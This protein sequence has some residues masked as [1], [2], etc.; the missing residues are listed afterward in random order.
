MKP[1]RIAVK[2]D[3]GNIRLYHR[4]LARMGFRFDGQK[5]VKTCRTK[6]NINWTKTFCK[7]KH[8]IFLFDNEY[9]ER[10]AD[11]RKTFFDNN[12]PDKNGKFRCVYCGKKLNR[13]RITVDHLYPVSAVS[14]SLELQKKLKSR[15]INSLNSKE[16]LVA[17]CWNCN[18]RKGTRMGIWS[19][20][21]RLGRHETFWRTRSVIRFFLVLF[22]LY[23]FSCIAF[24]PISGHQGQ[25][26]T[27]P[28]EQFLILLGG[29]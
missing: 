16:N 25:W 5:Y 14:K 24:L 15:G 10:S 11:Y 13:N 7:Q 6:K 1:I 28:A 4:D 18:M 19:L 17:A 3:R 27:Y 9:G 22:I 8:L 23:I 21:G 2:S 29:K 12:R 20:R 26:L